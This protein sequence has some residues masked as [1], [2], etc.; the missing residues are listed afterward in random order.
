VIA[1]E[2]VT[3]V[4]GALRTASLSDLVD[5]RSSGSSNGSP[6]RR[7]PGRPPNASA[8]PKASAN[9]PVGTGR[10]KRASSDEIQQQK[11]TAL[12]AAEKLKGGFSKGD[13]MRR[14]RSR[15]DLGRAL[16]LLVAE[17]KLTKKGERRLTRYWVK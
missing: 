8:A 16:T 7:G 15:V 11:D 13:V 10:R 5:E 17:G 1:D 2:F 9:Q 3:L 14:S 6:A 4:L 12:G